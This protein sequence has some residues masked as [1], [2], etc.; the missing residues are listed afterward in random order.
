MTADRWEINA[1]ILRTTHS[2]KKIV[3]GFEISQN[4]YPKSMP[5]SAGVDIHESLIAPTNNSNCS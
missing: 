3:Y 2:G 4:T 5:S 1:D